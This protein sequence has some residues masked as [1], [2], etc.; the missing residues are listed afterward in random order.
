MS[1]IGKKTEHSGQTITINGIHAPVETAK[2]A[3][4]KVST[5]L[6]FWWA[7]AAEQFKPLAVWHWF[8]DD[9]K[10][11]LSLPRKSTGYDAL[12]SDWVRLTLKP[13]FSSFFTSPALITCSLAF[14]L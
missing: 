1:A 13:S 11:I 6:S 12:A 9:L 5:L 8:C 4:T 7:Q 14:S 3:L 2:R 10:R